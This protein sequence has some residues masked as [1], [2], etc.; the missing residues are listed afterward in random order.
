MTMAIQIVITMTIIKITTKT[1]ITKIPIGIRML[2]TIIMTNEIKI[3][4]K[5]SIAIT[6]TIKKTI[7]KC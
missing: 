2:K 3:E 1:V 4:L 7:I 6:M 5:L